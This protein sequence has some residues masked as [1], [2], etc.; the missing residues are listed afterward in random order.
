[1]MKEKYLGISCNIIYELKLIIKDCCELD[2]GIYYF[3][4]ICKDVE[5]CSNEIELKVVRG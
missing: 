3:F 1:M 5:I 2:V 4:V